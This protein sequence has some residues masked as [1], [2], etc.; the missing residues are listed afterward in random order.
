MVSNFAQ[1]KPNIDQ[2]W[3]KKKQTYFLFYYPFSPLSSSLQHMREKRERKQKRSGCKEDVVTKRIV[4]ERE[5]DIIAKDAT[6]K[7]A[8]I[9][10]T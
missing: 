3:E 7:I 1:M 9:A 8:C 10:R 5:E 2:T 6:K 4:G